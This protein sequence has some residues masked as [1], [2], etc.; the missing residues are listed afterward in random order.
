MSHVVEAAEQLLHQEQGN[1]LQDGL[2]QVGCGRRAGSMAGRR[3]R[4]P[5]L[6]NALRLQSPCGPGCPGWA[7]RHSLRGPR[8][9]SLRRSRAP[10][11]GRGRHSGP[12]GPPA[13]VSA[14]I[15]VG[16]L[17]VQFKAPGS[18]SGFSAPV[19]RSARIPA[20]VWLR[21]LVHP[22]SGLQSFL[23]LQSR[24]RGS[25]WTPAL[26]QAGLCA[27][28]CLVQPSTSA[29]RPAQISCPSALVVPS[30]GYLAAAQLNPPEHRSGTCQLWDPDFQLRDQF[31]TGL[32]CLPGFGLQTPGVQGVSKKRAAGVEG[33]EQAFSARSLQLSPRPIASSCRATVDRHLAASHVARAFGFGGRGCYRV[34]STSLSFVATCRA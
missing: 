25:L 1:L 2:L 31:R 5:L 15:S 12:R 29:L 34:R 21:L 18:S 4:C 19:P 17:Q 33:P 27:L 26:T 3:P 10:G 13:S 32:R 28:V 9:R 6:C 7:L 24:P 11:R 20:A 23:A 30:L 14:F 22:G 8:T 16:L